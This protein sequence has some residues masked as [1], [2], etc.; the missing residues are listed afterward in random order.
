MKAQPTQVLTLATAKPAGV[1]INYDFSK[2]VLASMCPHP[3]LEERETNVV[4]G[5][6][7]IRTSGTFRYRPLAKAR[8]RPL[9]H[10]SKDASSV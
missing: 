5:D 1:T 4:N 7:R 2:A 8:F 9:S 6:R 3:D 10:V